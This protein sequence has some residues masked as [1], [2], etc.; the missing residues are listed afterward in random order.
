M[1]YNRLCDMRGLAEELVAKDREKARFENT[2]DMEKL[3]R[4]KSSYSEGS[5]ESLNQKLSEQ[6]R[7]YNE[8][9]EN[10]HGLKLRMKNV[11]DKLKPIY[12]KE[13]Q[14]T[15][16]LQELHNMEQKY[17]LLVLIRDHLEKAHNSFT[18]AYLS[19]LMEAFEKYYK[20]HHTRPRSRLLLTCRLICL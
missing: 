5:F 16:G 8:M 3:L 18:K 19:P 1:R 13:R 2:H 12:E 10:I 6:T 9:N 17:S 4:I 7:Q 15:Q 14:Y 11:E 20:K